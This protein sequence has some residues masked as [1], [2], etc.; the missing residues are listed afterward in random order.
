MLNF[1]YD[2]NL[3]GDIIKNFENQTKF[4]Y[5]VINYDK[6]Q[7][8]LKIV[9]KLIEKKYIKEKDSKKLIEVIESII[10]EL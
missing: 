4:Y 1:I 2:N 6:S 7:M 10:K 8:V 3:V 9:K 5:S